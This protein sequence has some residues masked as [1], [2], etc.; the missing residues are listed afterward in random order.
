MAGR[1]QC[2]ALPDGE[3]PN[4]T[5]IPSIV[6]VPLKRCRLIAAYVHIKNGQVGMVAPCQNKPLTVFRLANGAMQN[7]PDYTARGH[8]TA[9]QVQDHGSTCKNPDTTFSLQ[10]GGI[11]H[12]HPPGFRHARPQGRQGCI[13][14]GMVA[15]P[16]ATSNW[17]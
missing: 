5:P 9:N 1:R 14:V 16:R 13:T 7:K 17:R 6:P 12:T 4:G 8:Y 3:I 11:V 10:A 15:L 2:G